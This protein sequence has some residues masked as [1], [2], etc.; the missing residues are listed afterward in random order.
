MLIFTLDALG[1]FLWRSSVLIAIAYLLNA[2]LF[3]RCPGHRCATLAVCLLTMPLLWVCAE[4]RWSVGSDRPPRVRL[5]A[6]DPSGEHGERTDSSPARSMTAVGFLARTT[7]RLNEPGRQL[8]GALRDT[9]SPA[10][11]WM[12][13]TGTTLFFI[14]A[15]GV[16]MVFLRRCVRWRRW[17]LLLS[18]ST[19]VIDQALMAA[20]G[21]LRSL[22]GSKRSIELRRSVEVAGPC[23]TGIVRPVIL[24]PAELPEGE[25]ETRAI[26]A[27]EILHHRRRDL[28]LQALCD[29]VR[30]LF[31]F[32]PL[33]HLVSGSLSQEREKA[34]DLHVVRLLGRPQRYVDV[35]LEAARRGLDGGPGRCRVAAPL[36]GAARGLKRR[37]TMLLNQSRFHVS[38]R[39]A[40]FALS[41]GLVFAGLSS[42]LLLTAEVR[43]EEKAGPGPTISSFAVETGDPQRFRLYMGLTSV[44]KVE[45]DGRELAATSWTYHQEEEQLEVR[46]AVANARNLLAT[47]PLRLP[48]VYNLNQLCSDQVEIAVGK[49]KLL[50][51]KEFTV[52]VENRSIRL[53]TDI[54]GWTGSPYSI[55]YEKAP[56]IFT[57]IMTSSPGPGR[58]SKKQVEAQVPAELDSARLVATDQPGTFRLSWELDSVAAVK[59]AR[60]RDDGS[61]DDP[62]L[63]KPAEYR[64]EAEGSL[65]VLKIPVDPDTDRVTV[66]GK[67]VIPWRWNISGLEPGTLKITLVDRVAQ[68]GVD[69]SLDESTGRVEFLNAEDCGE[70]TRYLLEYVAE[71]STG[72]SSFQL[73]DRGLSRSDSEQARASRPVLGP[74][75]QHLQPTGL[76]RTDDPRVFVPQSPVGEGAWKLT[77][78]SKNGSGERSTWER[79]QE[80][81]FDPAYQRV[82]LQTDSEVDPKRQE[83]ALWCDGVPW[84]AFQFPDPIDTDALRLS[85]NGRPLVAGSDYVLHADDRSL[86]LVPA[87]FGKPMGLWHLEIAMGRWKTERS[88]Y[89][90]ST[91]VVAGGRP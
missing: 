50:P 55:S 23:A 58:R 32:Q 6:E 5:G 2:T 38:R 79:G 36:G 42:L 61:R 66:H 76:W 31:W 45:L 47:G 8:A 64:F 1:P 72:K 37:I 43:G 18:R 49:R 29:L 13:A 77:V 16:L 90:A 71:T 75:G 46:V 44:E 26:L 10:A 78:S 41:M 62:V 22:L 28:H 27:H 52:D 70:E 74:R 24:L 11:T 15:L 4:A 7:D 14:W 83:I 82:I 48:Y 9:P 73:G 35:L 20:F 80:F 53:L 68:E 3:R 85:V 17:R 39:P 81:L 84:N 21:E 30:T 60:R 25:G 91:T 87:A 57:G 12:P 33:L 89:H 67:R 69:Y 56:G 40:R 65:L 51:G 54:S 34:V 63:L 19:P 59:L 88:N 86:L